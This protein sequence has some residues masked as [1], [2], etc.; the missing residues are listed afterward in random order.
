MLLP[1][2]KNQTNY[3]LS[4]FTFLIYN[5]GTVN[6]CLSDNSQKSKMK[7]NKNFLKNKRNYIIKTDLGLP[8]ECWL[9][10]FL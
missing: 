5:K 9:L 6:C 4:C 8:E 2:G 10:A 1:F 7:H 3:K